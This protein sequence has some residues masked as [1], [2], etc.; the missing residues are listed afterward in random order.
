[1]G[2]LVSCIDFYLEA[3]TWYPIECVVCCQCHE[4]ERDLRYHR[5]CYDFSYWHSYS[6]SLLVW[7]LC[8]GAAPRQPRPLWLL[9]CVFHSRCFRLFVVQWRIDWR[10]IIEG[11]F[12]I[13]KHSRQQ[14][15]N[16]IQHTKA[17]QSNHPTQLN[18]TLTDSNHKLIGRQVTM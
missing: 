15:K 8:Y 1:M 10:V 2:E 13:H 3:D 16:S 4:R 9:T 18:P 12:G 5:V 7:V 11:W 6:S 14:Q 17:R